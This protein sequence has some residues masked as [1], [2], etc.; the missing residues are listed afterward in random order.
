MRVRVRQRCAKV[1]LF[2]CVRCVQANHTDPND[3]RQKSTYPSTTPP[4]TQ[5]PKQI[6][7][8]CVAK[9]DGFELFLSLSKSYVAPIR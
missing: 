4:S 9:H 7:V 1:E 8:K 6:R 2:Y 3:P 5:N